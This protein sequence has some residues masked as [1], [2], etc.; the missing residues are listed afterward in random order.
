SECDLAPAVEVGR[1]GR[2]R[3]RRHHDGPR[4]PRNAE[5]DR[6]VAHGLPAHRRSLFDS[7]S[8]HIAKSVNCEPEIRSSA[9]RT[10]VPTLTSLPAM[11][12]AISMIPRTRPVKVARKPNA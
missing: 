2:R 7:M 9:T 6:E 8:N 12:Y 11:R 4:Q 5:H 10:T 3:P 1:M